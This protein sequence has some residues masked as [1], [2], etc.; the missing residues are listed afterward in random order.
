MY[1]KV[2]KECFTPSTLKPGQEGD[3][4]EFFAKVTGYGYNDMISLPTLTKDS[5]LENLKRR[6]KSEM[7]YTYVGDIIISVNPF[8]RLPI[9]TEGTL[10]SFKV[11]SARDMP[12]HIYSCASRAYDRLLLEQEANLIGLDDLAQHLLCLRRQFLHHALRVLGLQ[13]LQFLGNVFEIRL[14]AGHLL[15]GRDLIFLT[16]RSLVALE[17][18][19][20]LIQFGTQGIGISTGEMFTSV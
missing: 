3:A 10:H 12:P 14:F 9:Y 13:R 17:I 11:N 4:G 5:I 6:F 18:F 7:V 1:C 20:Q 16:H 19:D 15:S 2:C 8:T